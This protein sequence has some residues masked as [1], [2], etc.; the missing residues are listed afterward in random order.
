MLVAPLPSSVVRSVPPPLATSRHAPE[1]RRLLAAWLAV[2]IGVLA[3]VPAARGGATLGA[4][5][6]FWLV[7]APLIG[8]AWLERKALISAAR[9]RYGRPR[10]RRQARRLGRSA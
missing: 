10:R 6:P 5:V 1:L 4:T 7:A 2:G 9:I 3:V 8:L